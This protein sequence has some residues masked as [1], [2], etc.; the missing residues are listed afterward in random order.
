MATSDHGRAVMAA[1]GGGPATGA[2]G[3]FLHER[4]VV[5][6]TQFALGVD[7][8]TGSARAFLFDGSGRRH[9]G[10]RLRYTWR[11]SNDGAVEANADDAADLTFNAMDGALAHLPAGGSIVA[12][13]FSTLWHTL[14]GV[15]GSGRPVTPVIGWNDARATDAARSLRR[16]LD[17]EQVHQRTGA[18]LHPSYPPARLAWLR[19][20]QPELFQRVER[21]MSLPEYLWLRLTGT[22]VADV[23]IAAGSGLLNRFTLEWDDEVCEA[24]GVT[25]HQLGTI[26]AGN[27]AMVAGHEVPLT[28]GSGVS[29]PGGRWPQL[30]AATWRVPV[31]DGACANIGSGSTDAR[32]VA[33]SIGTSAAMRTVVHDGTAA[34]PAGLWSYRLDAD[35]A[36]LGGAISNGGIVRSWLQSL[37]KLPDDDVELDTL[38]S[39]RQ[40]AAHGLDMLPFLAGE[41][42]PDWPLDATAVI[43]GLRAAT[44]PLDL[45]QAGLEAVAYRLLLVRRLIADAAPSAVTIIAS[46]GA[47]RQSPYWAQLLTDVFGEPIQVAADAETSSRG[48]ALLA[49]QAAGEIADFRSLPPVT[50][51]TLE[52]DPQRHRAHAAAFIR[53]KELAGRFSV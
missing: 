26:A 21:W 19:T 7:L 18:M 33:L 23:S 50:T 49:L 52:P 38:L 36:L 53:H 24:V 1:Q 45:L 40:P 2:P 37:L 47:M 30:R 4:G 46:G 16:C 29:P 27:A 10:V 22:H 17:G 32:S 6:L 28:G 43:A 48:A 31:G 51:T 42:T 13:G 39:A 8:G 9:G 25:S 20:T 3:S 35:T 5:K 15:D 44:S 14:L 34:I 41:R 11:L 12:V